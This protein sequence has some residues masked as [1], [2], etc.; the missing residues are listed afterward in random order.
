M[1]YLKYEEPVRKINLPLI[2]KL[3]HKIALLY[4]AMRW[5]AWHLNTNCH[6]V[7]RYQYNSFEFDHVWLTL[8]G[9]S[10]AI[11]KYLL[12]ADCIHVPIPFIYLSVHHL[13]IFLSPVEPSHSIIT[14][15][16]NECKTNVGLS[17][18]SR[19]CWMSADIVDSAIA[20]LISSLLLFCSPW[21]WTGDSS[22]SLWGLRHF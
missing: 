21:G 5:S 3:Q 19:H 9:S 14:V 11:L 13:C 6:T 4:K 1:K 16:N 2:G 15:H 7:Q 22:S 8:H 20:V 10:A 18:N 12:L 17:N